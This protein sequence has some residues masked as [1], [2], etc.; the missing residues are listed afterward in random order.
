MSESKK[1]R[2]WLLI[3]SLQ[4]G[5]ANKNLVDLANGLDHEE[6]DVTVWTI[7]PDDTLA[8]ELSPA[9]THRSLDASGK[10]DLG[11][12]VE[13]LRVVRRESPDVLHS[14]LFFDNLLARLSRVT[15]P[16][17][18]VVSGVFSAPTDRPWI[19]SF[20]DR[21][22]TGLCD[23][24][25]A[26]SEA[27][28]SLAVRRGTPPTHVSTIPNAREVSLFWDAAE[29]SG[30]RSSLGIPPDATV[31]GTVGRLVP[32]KGHR[33]LLAAWPTVLR[34]NPDAHLVVVGDG[35]E[36]QALESLTRDYDCR[37]SVTFTGRRSDVPELLA[38]FD[39][40]AFPSH[41]EGMPGAV[42]EAMAAGVPTVGTRVPGTTELVD[43][44]ETGVLV[45]A[46][47]PDELATAIDE[48]L[49]DPSRRERLGRKASQVAGAQFSL[50]R[51][52]ESHSQLYRDLAGQT[53]SRS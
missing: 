38:T 8:P 36:R 2:L 15:S 42:I 33:D 43:D 41:Y 12:V 9:V 22:T 32:V 24:V 28:A 19:R 40:F 49:S 39:V 45:E 7:L 30:L 21:L 44:G 51:L 10:F 25:V 1:I 50:D 53:E 13:F 34:A 6:F 3:G 46:E 16:Q 47:S 17:T 31:V 26:N 27:C 4:T 23:H 18:A 52:V 5:G 14:F 29:P 48:L 37:D 11:A 20:L 35:P